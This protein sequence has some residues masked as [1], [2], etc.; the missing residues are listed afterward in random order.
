MIKCNIFVD[1]SNLSGSLSKIQLNVDDYSKFYNYIF[2]QAIDKWAESFLDRIQGN[3]TLSKVHWYVVGSIDELDLTNKSLLEDLRRFFK[4]DNDLYRVY[5]KE[6]SANNPGKDQK[7][8]EEEAWKK[9]FEDSKIWYEKRVK[10][11]DDRKKFHYYIQTNCDF[12]D[13]KDVGH[14]KVD[15]IHRSL[16]EK[17][18]D[19][20][21]SVDMVTLIDN[22]DLAILISGDADGIP[23]L[24]YLKRK[25]KTVAVVD[26]IHG[27]SPAQKGK[28]SSSKL[29]AASDFVVPIYE[30]DLLKNKIAIKK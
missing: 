23:S 5:L 11:I 29:K 18:V 2:H 4:N 13:M 10:S 9:L 3:I 6:A 12:I 25:G 22:Y 7:T 30:T 26:F 19:T 28:Q 17:G 14:W 8:I 27:G 15:F 24:D 1:G 21:F 16:E 20:S